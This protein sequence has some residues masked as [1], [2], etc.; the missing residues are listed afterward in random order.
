MRTAGS[1]DVFIAGYTGGNSAANVQAFIDAQNPNGTT[2]SVTQVAS[3][4]YNN[5]PAVPLP[6]P[7]LP[8][9]PPRTVMGL[10]PA[11]GPH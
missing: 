11:I 9:L 7:N 2:F 1:N 5:G 10:A 6:A 4:T 8:E 3:G